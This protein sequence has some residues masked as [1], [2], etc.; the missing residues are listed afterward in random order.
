[1]VDGRPSAALCQRQ[2]NKVEGGT[3]ALDINHHGDP[4][5]AGDGKVPVCQQPATGRCHRCQRALCAHHLPIDSLCVDCEFAFVPLHRH[6]R[7]RARLA[8]V[9]LGIC[10]FLGVFATPMAEQS[11][12]G[13]LLLQGTVA[14]AAAAM[15]LTVG[16]LVLHH[17]RRQFIATLAGQGANEAALGPRRCSAIALTVFPSSTRARRPGLTYDPPPARTREAPP[18]GHRTF[19]R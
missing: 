19:W 16:R 17:R 11:I 12:W 2:T 4:G 9:L 8:A 5:E 14:A 13:T 6:I 10:G 15:A 1:M 18:I 3:A 7:R